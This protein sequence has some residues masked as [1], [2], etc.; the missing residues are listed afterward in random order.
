MDI[1]KIGT[2]LGTFEVDAI[3]VPEHKLKKIED[4][5]E[6]VLNDPGNW[7]ALVYAANRV[8]DRPNE[9]GNI[10]L[11]PIFENDDSLNTYIEKAE[12]SWAKLR[13]Y[14]E[15]LYERSHRRINYYEMPN[16]YFDIVQIHERFHALHHRTKDRKGKIWERFS[17]V[18][19][20]YKELL[21]QIFTYKYIENYQPKLMDDFLEL[22]KKQSFIYQTWRGFKDISWQDTINLYW[23]IRNRINNNKPLGI[24]KQI[25]EVIMAKHPLHEKIGTKIIECSKSQSNIQIYADHCFDTKAQNPLYPVN[26]KSRA[27]CYCNVDILII[28][29]NEIKVIIEIEESD[30]KPTHICGKFYTSALSKYYIHPVNT[31]DQPIPMSEDVVFIQ[32]ID[33]SNLEEKSQKQEQLT[34]IKNS[35]QGNLPL[36]NSKISNYHL[37]MF[38]GQCDQNAMDRLILEVKGSI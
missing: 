18:P 25:E 4:R 15:Y 19:S 32:V 34:R 38:N 30:I 2:S 3:K 23:E 16:N 26:Q 9:E 27:T 21:A 35:I 31:K 13:I 36:R 7:E 6:L 17:N 11:S 22:N 29:N 33:I 12:W 1:T 37:I 28:K 8:L 20:F 14:G 10:D 24:L 5:D